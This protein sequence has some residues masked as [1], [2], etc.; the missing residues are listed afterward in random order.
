MR[1]RPQTRG[2]T[3]SL[4]SD[5]PL[6]TPAPAASS[7]RC[8]RLVGS[9]GPRAPPGF[10]RPGRWRQAG[11]VAG[12]WPVPSAGDQFCAAYCP[13]LNAR[14]FR[15]TFCLVLSSGRSRR[16]GA[17]RTS[18][19]RMGTGINPSVKFQSL[20]SHLWMLIPLS[21]TFCI[22]YKAIFKVHVYFFLVG[23]LIIS[24]PRSPS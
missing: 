18:Y 3:R 20:I 4:P 12:L 23:I 19:L 2:G 16:A 11:R 8:P 10:L 21:M 5:A 13:R 7:Q 15:L 1:I 17:S 6:Q 24:F 9:A 14:A 22:M